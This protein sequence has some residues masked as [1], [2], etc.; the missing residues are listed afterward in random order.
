MEDSFGAL[1]AETWGLVSKVVPEVELSTATQALAE[2]LA[3]IEPRVVGAT[4]RLVSTSHERTMAEQLNAEMSELIGCMQADPFRDAVRRF[5][6]GTSRSEGE[7]VSA[8]ARLRLQPRLDSP[9]QPEA[10]LSVIARE[11]DHETDLPMA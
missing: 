3:S 10:H 1:H 2:R 7:V 4:K 6:G 11:R 9:Q 5:V 8:G